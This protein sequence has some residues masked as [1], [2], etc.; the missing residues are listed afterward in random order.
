MKIARW[1]IRLSIILVVL[2]ALIFLAKILI[3]GDN[4]ESN[5]LSYL[6]NALGF[7]PLN[8]L[9]VTLIL[10]GMLA[11]RAAAE[12]KE[13]MK[14]V[15][16]LFFTEFGTE[17]LRIFLSGDPAKEQIAAQIAPDKSW[18]K[19]EYKKAVHS[20]E[21]LCRKTRPDAAALYDIRTLLKNNHEFMLRLIENPVFLEQS[22]V[23]KLVQDLFHLETELASRKEIAEDAKADFAHL[24][25]DVNRV[26]PS[27]M[28]VWL[29]HMEYLSKH[30]PYLLSY[31][32]RT[33]PFLDEDD[34]VVKE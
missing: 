30:Y 32:L 18:K 33:S 17:L 4:S 15:L 9:F 8:V 7:L 13:K 26:Y 27:L 22:T 31:S 11:R 5:T 10:N 2:S 14:M 20:A 23:F 6:F 28:T 12:R 29:S 16:G 24:L 25:G 19:E 34:V 3:I 21:T 1:T